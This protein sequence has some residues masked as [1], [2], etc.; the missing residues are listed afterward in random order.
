VPQEIDGEYLYY[1]L[2]LLTPI[3]K[4]LSAGTT[5]NEVSKRDIRT[6]HCSIPA[7]PDEQTAIAR[8]LDAVDGAIERARDSIEVATKV[9]N[10]LVQDFFYAA[11]GVSAAVR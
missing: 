4:R 11:L 5:F 3:I 2:D 8:I 10:A 7:I 9:K 6:V 1:L